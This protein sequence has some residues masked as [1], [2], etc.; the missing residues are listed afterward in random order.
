M[1]LLNG[2]VKHSISFFPTAAQVRKWS[3]SVDSVIMSEQLISVE[4]L[5]LHVQ[6]S[7]KVHYADF[8]V[9]IDGTV[10]KYK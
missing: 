10:K 3:R 5:K 9:E 8:C 4:V 7:V 1:M 6:S 2:T